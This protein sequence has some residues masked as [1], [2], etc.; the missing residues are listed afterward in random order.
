VSTKQQGRADFLELGSWNVQCGLCGRKRKNSDMKQLPPGVP[1]A[2]LYVCNDHEYQRNP[3]DYVRG[4]PDI[5]TP[6]WTQPQTDTI[7]EPTYAADSD[8]DQTIATDVTYESVLNIFEGVT[9]PTL[10][11]TGAGT[12]V[13]NNWGVVEVLV[14]SSATIVLRNY[15]VWPV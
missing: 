3:Q 11:L 12:I 7:I 13:I 1:G 14:N 8:G 9:V 6:P 5:Q 2:G 15:G 10:T 4:I